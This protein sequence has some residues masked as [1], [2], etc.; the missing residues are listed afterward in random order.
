[1]T[2]SQCHT[3]G[4]IDQEKYCQRRQ[5]EILDE[6][7]S[8]FEEDALDPNDEAPPKK[9][10]RRIILGRRAEN[11][12]LEVITP[13]DS[14]WYTLYVSCPNINCPRFQ[15]K[16]QGRFCMPYDSFCTFIADARASF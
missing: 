4:E 12:E 7:A 1:M 8:D 15:R 6:W 3:D 14:M 5:L 16:F 13:T 11:G 10:V 2:L 9:R